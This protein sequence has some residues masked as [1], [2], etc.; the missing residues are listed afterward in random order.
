MKTLH[1]L[2]NRRYQIVLLL[3][4]TGSS[5]LLSCKKENT[6]APVLQ[7]LKLSYTGSSDAL[8]EGRYAIRLLQNGDYTCFTGGS[9]YAPINNITSS[10]NTDVYNHKTAMWT[11]YGLSVK[12]EY[13]AAAVLN[14]KL[15]MAGGINPNSTFSSVADVFDLA[16]GQ[17]IPAVLSQA[18]AYFAAA[19]A[20]NKILFG[21][22]SPSND[23]VSSRVDIYNTQTGQWTT[24]T[25]SLARTNLAAG[26]IGNKIVFAGGVAI[27]SSHQGYYSDRV[28]IYDTQTGQWTQAT[29][30]Q[31][32]Y[33][34]MKI[35]TAGNKLLIA[36]GATTT[37]YETVDVYDV[38]TNLWTTINLTGNTLNYMLACSSNSQIFFTTCSGSAA[39]FTK[40]HIYHTA[41]GQLNTIQLPVPVRSSAIAAS[42]NKVVISAGIMSD[43]LTRKVFVYDTQSGS[44]DTTSFNLPEKRV[45]VTAAVAGN[46]ILIAGGLGN[47]EMPSGPQQQLTNFK[48][49][50]VFELRH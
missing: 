19:G 26:A 4:L 16:T 17:T 9:I 23:K 14:N 8:T 7:P 18:R 3:A 1:L 49:V 28:D 20:G 21:G 29:L 31:P 12:R 25:L 37:N 33:Q 2:M 47:N 48:K 27:N 46:K 11:R 15:V 50:S 42:G 30:S 5:I 22:G 41:N 45:S 44:F 10:I 40:L 13:Y 35:V 24:D 6:E 39:N 43:T 38:Q 36:G 32:R 34:D